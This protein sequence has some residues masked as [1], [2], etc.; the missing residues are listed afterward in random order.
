MEFIK[1]EGKILVTD[2]GK[3]ILLRGFGLGGWLLPEG[4]MWKLFTQCDRPRRME[5]L[6]EGLCG[7]EYAAEFW[8]RYFSGY[9]TIRDVELIAREGFN[10]VRLPMNA[11]HL[12]DQNF[13]RIDA[14]ISWCK[15]WDI[16]VILDMHGA[17]GGQTG[18]NIDDSEDDTPRLFIE[19]RY[20]DELVELWR[21]LA[22][23]YAGEP[24][25]AGYDLL[26]E[27]L[28]NWSS[29]YNPLL[30]PLYRRIT[31]AIR[32]EDKRHLIILEGVHWATDWSVFEELAEHPPDDNLMLQFHKYWNI[33]DSESIAPYTAMREKL[34]V[35]IFMGEGGENNLEWYA[36]LFS[37]LESENIS[38]SFWSYKKMDCGNSPVSFPRPSQWDKIIAFIDGGAALAEEAARGIF[39]E[40]L[41]NLTFKDYVNKP[42]LCAIKHEA[43]LTLPAEYFSGCHVTRERIPGAALRLKTPVDIRFVNGKTGEP[44]YKRYGGEEQ[45]E[46]ERLCVA[47]RA[48]EWLQYDFSTIE[49]GGWL[50]KILC[51]PEAGPANLTVQLDGLRPTVLHAPEEWGE[52]ALEFLMLKKGAHRLKIQATN[53][54]L[55]RN[56]SIEHSPVSSQIPPPA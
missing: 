34:G 46:E 16:Y 40:F 41:Q 4:Y 8:K 21:S 54:L 10:C 28:P 43:P 29:E 5:K 32:T 30:M 52:T 24:A 35:P 9:I 38:W 19:E 14:L 44:D 7:E 2:S 56:W 31:S 11:R 6:I 37:M 13:G 39:N 17:P 50:I 20:Q 42:V 47:L 3:P 27:P 23:R 15:E 51:K 33:P 36:G 49:E 12:D 22:K 53:S 25:V 26:N 55:L 45:P 1:T 18:T 48:G